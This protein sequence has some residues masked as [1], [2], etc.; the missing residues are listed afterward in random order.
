MRLLKQETI[1]FITLLLT[2]LV[3]VS[4]LPAFSPKTAEASSAN[5]SSSWRGIEKQIDGEDTY[6]ALLARSGSVDRDPQSQ[7]LS[8]EETAMLERLQELFTAESSALGNGAC[9]INGTTGSGSPD[10]AGVSGAQLGRLFRNAI[11][12]A[13][14]S[15][16]Y[17]GLFNAATTYNYDAYSFTNSAAV[18]VCVT[19]NFDPNS[20]GATLCRTNAHASAYLGSYDPNNQSA[21]YVG[22][23]GSSITQPF[24]FEVPA[25]QAFVVVVTNTASQAACNYSFSLD[26]VFCQLFNTCLQDDSAGY[27]L[28]VN[29]DTGEYQ[30]ANCNGIVIGGIGTLIRKGCTISLQHNAVDRRVLA[31]IDNCQKKATASIRLLSQGSSFTITDRNTANNT[32]GCQ[33]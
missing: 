28:Q 18:A 7:P 6:L 10:K 20:G 1:C 22:D 9:T 12:S 19:I 14:P 26:S 16:V 31:K 32:C 29:T 23:V 13:C 21:N 15:K 11:P 33:N 24:S 27:S 8:A 25:G 3:V 2:G 4:G 17:P 30:F 5:L